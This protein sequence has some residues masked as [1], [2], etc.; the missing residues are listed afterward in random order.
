MF[1]TCLI[2]FGNVFWAFWKIEGFSSF[3]E[4]F[5]VST[6]QGA[7][8]NFF[9]KNNLKTSSKL[10]WTLLGK[11][12]DTF[13]FSNFFDFFIEFFQVS[14]LKG[15]LVNLFLPKKLAQSMF[16]TCLNFLG[17]LFGH[18]EKKWK[19]FLFSDVFPCFDP[20][21]CTGQYFFPEKNLKTSSTLVWKLL[22]TFLD[23]FRNS[24]FS[25]FFRISASFDLQGAL[26]KK[27][28]KKISSKQIW[29]LLEMFFGILKKWDFFPFFWISFD[30][31]TLQ[32]ALGE[33][34]HRK[35]Y[36]EAC[37]KHVWTLLGTYLG[38]LKKWKFSSFLKFFPVWNF[39]GAQG[40]F[41][42]E[43]YLK[44]SSKLVWTLL[45]T[46]W[47]LLRNHFFFV[48]S[49]NFYKIRSPGCT[50]Q[51]NFGKNY[52]KQVWTL[53]ER[54]FEILELWKLFDFCGFFLS[55]LCAL[56]T[57]FSVEKLNHNI[58]K[59]CFWEHFRTIL[60][61]SKFFLFLRFFPSLDPPRCT[62]A[63]LSKQNYP[64]TGS[65][66]VWTIL[67]T[68]LDTLEILK[69]SIF[70]NLFLTRPSTVHC[71]KFL[72]KKLP[73][74]MFKTC[75][76]AFGNVFWAFWRIEGFSSFLE[77][78]QVST[79]QGSLGNFF[80]KNRLKTSSK[81]VWKLLRT[82]FD[83]FRKSIFF[84]FFSNFC[85]FWSPGCTGQEKFEK[86]QL[87]TNLD[88][89][90][91]VFRDFEKMR[92]FPFF[93][94]FFDFSTLQDAL[95]EIFHRKK[96]LGACWKHVRT[97]LGTYLRILKKW[98]F[99]SFLKFFPVW[100]FQ[101]ALGS[102]FWE[103]YLETSSKLVWTLLRTFWTL[104]R[105]Q[106]FFRFFYEFL[107]NSIS[108]LHWARKVRKKLPQASLD[109]FGK[110]FRD[111]GTL[112][113]F[114]VLWIFLSLLCALGT[115]FSV[116][117]LNQNILKQCFWEHF[118]T[119]LKFSKFFLFLKFFPSLDPPRCTGDFFSKQNYLKT[120]SEYVWTILGTVLDTLEILNFSIFP[121]FSLLDPPG[122]TVQNFYRKNYLE[123]CSKHVWLL[124]GTFFGHFE[125][126]KVFPVFWSFSKFRLS[127]VHWAIFSEKIT[128][129]Q[130]QN[131]FGH[132]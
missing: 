52:L 92:F 120:G 3:L 110:V 93:W 57:A 116:E 80:R 43:N 62:G 28:S 22:R 77:F 45:R 103:N 82:F 10:V 32:D 8:G 46:F 64:K 41:F 37:W 115:A 12:L 124:L 101:G 105:N 56:G 72:P 84:D 47:T 69:F 21:G 63:F 25:I 42:R 7:L 94:I 60:K 123:T 58:L 130:V 113:S 88:T 85:K 117:K 65:E 81:L 9:R 19:F 102:F 97:L 4:F 74:N 66:H 11:F 109:T 75:L 35:K 26:V 104:L 86:N 24:I 122:C 78:F 114:R 51:E 40:D 121:I 59:Q 38:I 131:L 129:K 14:T 17:N 54:F 125:K 27:S 29:T 128:S 44:I 36:L 79:L 96:Y 107:Q 76:I 118:R 23:T 18:F 13:E 98:K 16:K 34:F 119:I 55:V 73:R 89:F 132:F 112:K 68:V 111:F 15:A 106:I 33:I 90:G 67:G 50:G 127:R 53:L 91:N 61:I 126:L 31:S 5:Q 6:L 1:K 20:P 48:F 71:A 83:T 49:S 70:S 87:K 2:A 100:T 39:Q 30:F 99:S 108:R 95:G